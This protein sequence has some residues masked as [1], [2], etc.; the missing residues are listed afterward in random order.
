MADSGDLLKLPPELKSNTDPVDGNPFP[1]GDVKHDIWKEA[2]RDAQRELHLLQFNFLEEPLSTSEGLDSWRVRLAVSKFD[3][4][5]KRDVSVVWDDAALHEYDHWLESHANAWMRFYANTYSESN[6]LN[7]LLLDLRLQLIKRIE[8]WKSIARGFVSEQQMLIAR[9][10]RQSTNDSHRVTSNDVNTEGFVTNRRAPEVI[11]E[12]QKAGKGGRP[13]KQRLDGETI[14]AARGE[15]KQTVFAKLCGISVD[16]LQRAER[17][18]G[19]SESTTRKIA[20]Y[21]KTLEKDTPQKPQ[22]P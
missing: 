1:E 19:S 13:V 21:L 15:R 14:K 22:R 3:I 12:K 20:K 2:T 7:R 10:N 9:A 8:L 4:W 16:T 17:N 6:T 18:G 5:S 11:K